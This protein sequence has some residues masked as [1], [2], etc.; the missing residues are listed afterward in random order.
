MVQRRWATVDLLV[1][2]FLG[3]VGG[4]GCVCDS[5]WVPGYVNWV[6]HGWSLFVSLALTHTDPFSP[7]ITLLPHQQGKSDA[8]VKS[9]QL[10]E[11]KNGRCVFFFKKRHT[12]LSTPPFP[13]PL[14]THQPINRTNQSNQT[15]L[16]THLQP[17]HDRRHGLRG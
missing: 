16:H 2:F 1:F 13:F 4:K 5:C 12:Q 11:I 7:L 6:G 3:V 8:A 10:K 9:M 17:G 14:H 15:H